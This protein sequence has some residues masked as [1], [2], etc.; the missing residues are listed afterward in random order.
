MVLADPSFV[1]AQLVKPLDQLQIALDGQGWVLIQR[2]KRRDEGAKAQ[3]GSEH[4]SL[5][6]SN[7]R[8]EIRLP[9]GIAPA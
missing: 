6:V 8:S 5:G 9:P 7:D 4:G 3:P 2:M 1:I